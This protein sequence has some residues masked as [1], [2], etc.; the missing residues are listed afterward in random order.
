ML[1]GKG[2]GS[3]AEAG[4][5]A[6]PPAPPP[7][8]L[9]PEPQPACRLCWG[10]A[11]GEEG[12]ALLTPCRCRGSVRHIHARCLA[13]W[14]RA[15]L[16]QGL[17]M[18]RAARCELCQGLYNAPLEGCDAWLDAEGKPAGGRR[19]RGR[20]GGAAAAWACRSLAALARR[21]AS[22]ARGTLR[23]AA[24]VG[25]WPALALRLWKGWLLARGT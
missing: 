10:E 24:T 21:A 4:G 7:Q 23:D 13:G 18:A 11:D 5:A 3:G 8:Q 19:R 2:S 6:A 25:R 9:Q 17:G 14:R 20:R 16:C 1:S 15:L 22:G 12:G